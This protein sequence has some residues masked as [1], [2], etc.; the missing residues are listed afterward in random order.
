VSNALRA[1]G[2][3]V[4]NMITFGTPLFPGTINAAL[5]PGVQVTNFTAAS[6]GDVL[7]NA[8]SGPNVINVPVVNMTAEGTKDFLTA[9]TGYWN[10]AMVISVVQQLIKP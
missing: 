6:S 8:L 3:A 1:S 9:H 7:A 5:P 10:N 4:D 2:I